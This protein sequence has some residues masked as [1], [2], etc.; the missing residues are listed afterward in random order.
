MFSLL[1]KLRNLKFR[2]VYTKRQLKSNGVLLNLI[3]N[4]VNKKVIF[5]N[6]KMEKNIIQNCKY[7]TGE[8]T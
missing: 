7:P 2:N 8:M 3:N 1:V 4:L 6:N 5:I